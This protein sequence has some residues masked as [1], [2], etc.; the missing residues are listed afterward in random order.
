VAA[1]S[2]RLTRRIVAQPALAAFHPRKIKPGPEFETDDDLARVA[3]DIGTT[4]FHPVGTCRTGRDGDVQAALDARLRVRGVAGLR[5]V[6]ASVTPGIISGSTHSPTLMIAERAAEWV[7]E[8][9]RS[10][11]T[12]VHA[13]RETPD[14][15][16]SYASIQCMYFHALCTNL[17]HQ[18]AEGGTRRQNRPSERL[19][20][21][22]GGATC[23]RQDINRRRA[24]PKGRALLS[25]LGVYLDVRFGRRRASRRLRTASVDGVV[26]HR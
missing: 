20:D 26:H 22:A 12:M 18:G 4:I 14:V 10:R 9:R 13:R 15:Q 3:D 5:V 6:D 2:L 19:S 24:L 1:A 16:S 11:A 23:D 25:V 21:E 8:I 7:R 17:V